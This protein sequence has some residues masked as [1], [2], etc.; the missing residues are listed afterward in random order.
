MRFAIH[1]NVYHTHP[2]S[3]G[4][5]HMLEHAW[6]RNRVSGDGTFY[7][8]SGFANYNGGVRFY[9]TIKSHIENGGQCVVYLGGSSSQKLSSKQVVEELLRIGCNVN[10]INRKR[11]LH[12]KCYGLHSANGDALIISSGNFTGPGMSQ[13]IEAS[14]M[15]E[16]AQLEEVGFSWNDLIH[17]INLQNWEIYRPSLAEIDNRFDPAWGLLYNEL[18]R[19]IQLEDDQEVTMIITLSGSDTARIQAQP[20][21]SA[22]KGTQYFWLSKDSYDFFPP[23]T[24][25]NN[26]GYKRTYSAIINMH[27]VDL[28]ITEK[29]R[30]T[31]E[32]E[33]N[34]DFRLGTSC[35]RSTRLANRDDI[36]A[37]SRLGEYDY[38]L[39][40][41]RQDSILYD[42]LLHHA[43]NRIGHQDKRYGYIANSDFF[44]ILGNE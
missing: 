5:L 28:G 2:E 32:A 7:I 31:F 18:A 25:P 24:I 26:R 8:I 44:E 43:I 15:I 3:K 16:G 11:I 12:A 17:S 23:L 39:R 36:A 13:N 33:N 38:E 20:G 30:V 14:F 6:I 37:I 40:I 10:L 21:T 29:S 22:H 41:I 27:Y 4:L 1:P 42:R 35:L 34:A 19:E 9:E